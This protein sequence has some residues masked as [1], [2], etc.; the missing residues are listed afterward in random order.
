MPSRPRFQNYT[1]VESIQVSRD[2]TGKVGAGLSGSYGLVLPYLLDSVAKHRFGPL[3]VLFKI[4][5][6]Y[7]FPEL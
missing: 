1:G 7:L 2:K 3:P 6:S 5:P 4:F